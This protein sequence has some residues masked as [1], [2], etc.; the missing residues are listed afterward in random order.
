MRLRRPGRSEV[1]LRILLEHC[2]TAV[3]AKVVV[4]AFVMK[5]SRIVAYLHPAND[6]EMRRRRP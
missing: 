4:N 1:A 2:A 6:V 3:A 5:A